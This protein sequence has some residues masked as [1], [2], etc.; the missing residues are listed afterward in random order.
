MWLIPI[1]A[2]YSFL[3]SSVKSEFTIDHVL[4]MSFIMDV[5]MLPA[6][7]VEVAS[8]AALD[9][10]PINAAIEAAIEATLAI[11]YEEVYYNIA[12]QITHP[13]DLLRFA[14]ASQTTRKLVALLLKRSR[15]EVCVNVKVADTTSYANFVNLKLAAG[16]SDDGYIVFKEW[17][18]ILLET[19]SRMH[20]LQRTQHYKNIRGMMF[21]NA[22]I[23]PV[24]RFLP[25]TRCECG[26]LTTN[27][28]LFNVVKLDN[29]ANGV[30]VSRIYRTLWNMRPSM[31]RRLILDCRHL[32][33][34]CMYATEL[35][36]TTVIALNNYAKATLSTT[37]H[38]NGS[39]ILLRNGRYRTLIT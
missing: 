37:L 13:A 36:Q 28:L 20:E 12:L 19:T 38:L 3:Y 18:N 23:T 24:G 34:R 2:D 10:A 6:A 39:K 17:C 27:R 15:M 31:S 4:I 8:P 1:M 33:T 5:D 7:G 29:V 25:M 16:A 14:A 21:V 11:E 9:I 32:C 35:D 30:P 22:Y 26:L